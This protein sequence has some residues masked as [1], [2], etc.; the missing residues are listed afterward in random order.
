MTL[1]AAGKGMLPSTDEP[2]FRESGRMTEASDTVDW[3]R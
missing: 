3:Y 2:R 1:V